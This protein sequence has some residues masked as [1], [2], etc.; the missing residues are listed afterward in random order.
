LVASAAGLGGCR[1][2]APVQ[3]SLT[4]L[5]DSIPAQLPGAFRRYLTEPTG[6]SAAASSQASLQVATLDRLAQ[7]FERLQTWHRASAATPWDAFWQQVL[8]WGRS[9]AP[10]D[11]VL[12][13]DA[14]LSSAIAQGLIQPID[15]TPLAQW[16]ALPELWRQLVQRDAAGQ[17]I[18]ASSGPATIWGAPYRWGTTAIVYRRDRFADLGWAPTDW[19]DLWRPELARRISLLDSDRETLGLTLKSLG[20]SYNSP[21]LGAVPEL[22]DRLAQLHQQ[23]LFY[24]STDYLQPLLL[25]DTWAAVGWSSD[26]LPA[27]AQRR[28]LAAIV[29]VSGTALWA[30]VWVR[31]AAAPTSPSANS[32]SANSPSANSPSAN[33]PAATSPSTAS[34]SA[35]PPAI[36]PLSDIDQAWINFCWDPSSAQAL[37]Q[38]GMGISPVASLPSS[39]DAD[40]A[41][42]RGSRPGDAVR[43][44]PAATI[45]RSE[46]LLPLPPAIAQ[47][48]RQFWT[49]MRNA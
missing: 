22:G 29:P 45:A 23:V 42:P 38:F 24:G 9:P 44:P 19:S 17:M 33:S 3:L 32:P 39:T 25:G 18:S 1:G 31:P 43:F 5:S 27:L 48:Y 11:W 36:A 16:S 40:P 6:A 7:A 28:E 34:P 47:Q 14:W 26:I 30:D 21:D 46:F 4:A 41:R 2:N 20:Q 8:P 10:T 12:L 13:G 35:T 49:A 37:S 15:P